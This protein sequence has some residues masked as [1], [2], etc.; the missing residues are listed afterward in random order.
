MVP[1]E[2][3]LV[4]GG[5]GFIGRQLVPRLRE[6]GFAVSVWQEDVR[7]I[8]S[9]TERFSFV[10][11]LAGVTTPAQFFNNPTESYSVNVVGTLKVLE[12]CSQVSASCIFASTA[13]VYGLHSKDVPISETQ[14]LK[15]TTPYAISKF[16]GEQISISFAEDHRVNLTIF[17]LFNVYG[18]GQGGTFLIPY[19]IDCL[20]KGNL[21]NLRTPNSVRDFVFVDDVVDAFCRAIRSSIAGCSV[22]N[23]GSGHGVTV[24]SAHKSVAKIINKQSSCGN[25]HGEETSGGCIADYSI[26]D[27]REAGRVLGWKP[28]ITL[29]DGL[30]MILA[31][32]SSTR[33]KLPG[34][35]V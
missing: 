31:K 18:F 23:I 8:C 10:I 30:N 22:I 19:L 21:P 26:A 16:L 28:A 5:N 35:H 7:H 6:I 12:Y 25:S 27:I 34:H 29:D 2:K 11:H 17:R 24:Q 20:C 3:V 33:S 13:G 4:T 9:L 32:S 1:C 14:I 15:P